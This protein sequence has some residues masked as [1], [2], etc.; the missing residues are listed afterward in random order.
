MFISHISDVSGTEGKPI[1]SHLCL[2]LT[3]QM[4]VA[5]KASQFTGFAQHDAQ[6][7]MAFLLDGLHE[8]SLLFCRYSQYEHLNFNRDHS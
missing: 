6:E 4:L 7:F 2:Y 3:F 8:V 5:Q 1:Y